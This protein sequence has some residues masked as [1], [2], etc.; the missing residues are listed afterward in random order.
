[1]RETH[2]LLVRHPE[3]EGNVEGRLM[4]RN[5]SPFTGRG[6]LQARRVPR[7]I[8]DFAPDEIWTSPLERA[9][10]VAKRA[11]RICRCPL[12]V[13]DRLIELDFGEAEGMTFE[14]IAE[15]GLVFNFRSREEPVAPGGESRAQIEGR[16]AAVCDE[17]TRRGGRYAIVAHGGV[18]RAAIVHLL[19]LGSD[20][21]WAFHIHN[22][23]MAYVRVVEGHGALEEY[24][25]G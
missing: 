23:Q 24:V 14:E 3:T 1:M 20:A 8:A 13:D 22:A 18:V 15:A 21:I 12:T 7:K 25:Q 11:E 10:V 9:L 17:L 5:E 2:I 16:T 19:G 6:F 4:G